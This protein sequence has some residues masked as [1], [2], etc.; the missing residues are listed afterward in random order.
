MTTFKKKMLSGFIGCVAGA[1]VFG[2]AFVTGSLP[3]WASG[4]I[5]V[6]TAVCGY[7]GTDK[8][9]S[10]DD[11]TSITTDNTESTEDTSTTE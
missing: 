3:S 11:A 4:V 5:A 2:T 1:V 9:L 6:V 10:V 7:L 8:I